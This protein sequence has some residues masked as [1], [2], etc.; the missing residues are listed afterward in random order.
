MEKSTLSAWVA[1]LAPRKGLLSWSKNAYKN[2]RNKKR[3]ILEKAIVDEKQTFTSENGLV[4]LG[5]VAPAASF[6]QSLRYHTFF[7]KKP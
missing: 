1:R 4:T 3:V 2:T 7:F 5:P 6:E